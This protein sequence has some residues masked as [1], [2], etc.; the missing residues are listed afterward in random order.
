MDVVKYIE[1]YDNNI[2]FI[3]LN[4]GPIEY[5]TEVANRVRSCILT[6]S[7]LLNVFVHFR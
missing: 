3:L 4:L 6:W 1:V 7:T 5:P 2:Q